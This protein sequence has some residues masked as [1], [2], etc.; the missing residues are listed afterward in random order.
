MKQVYL[1]MIFPDTGEVI[2]HKTD[3][4]DDY[5]SYIKYDLGIEVN[6]CKYMITEEI[7]INI[8]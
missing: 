2:I 3:T 4:K 6:S 8:N 7:N 1:T 5:K